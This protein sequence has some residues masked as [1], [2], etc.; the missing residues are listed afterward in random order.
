M[1]ARRAS[2]TRAAILT[3]AHELLAGGAGE[4]TVG[5][6]AARAG[7]SRLT[8]YQHF[9][10]HAGLLDALAASVRPAVPDLAGGSALEQLHSRIRASCQGWASNPTLFRRLPAAAEPATA[11]LDRELA[12]R[13]A[14][15]D[16]L[17]AGCSLK[18][19]EDVIAVVTSFATFD[20]LH[21]DGRR[22]KAAVGEILTRLAGAILTSPA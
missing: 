3:A 17:R 1:E 20:R 16:R 6:V 14:A 19:A 9:G 22:S 8:V 18:E 2:G 13:L 21:Q 5:A 4:P 7:V 10:S 11:E 15:D 12:T